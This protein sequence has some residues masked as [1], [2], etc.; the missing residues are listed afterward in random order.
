LIIRGG[1]DKRI[2]AQGRNVIDS[3]IELN[4]PVMHK[5]GGYIPICEHGVPEEVSWQDYR[6]YH[7]HCM[8]F[9]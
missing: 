8:E 6:Y 5:R 9:N 1:F 2:L 4:F 3:E 7:Q